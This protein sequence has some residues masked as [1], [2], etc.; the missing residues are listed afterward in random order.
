MRRLALWLLSFAFV[1]TAQAQLAPNAP[2][3]KPYDAYGQAQVDAMHKAIAPYVAQGQATYPAA[4]ARYLAGLPAGETFYVS[5]TLRESPGLEETVFIRVTSI[6]HGVVTG[7]L[8]SP[9]R[10]LHG[11]KL[12]QVQ[13]IP[14]KDVQDWLISRPDGTEEGNV[15]G[16]FLDTYHPP[17]S[18][19]KEKCAVMVSKGDGKTQLVVLPS[20]HV[21]TLSAEGEPFTLPPDAPA[22]SVAVDCGRD[23]IVP[24]PYDYRVVAAD[25]PFIITVADEGRLAALEIKDGRLQFRMMKG[26]VTPSEERQIQEF[27]DR[28][29]P[30]LKR[31]EKP[32]TQATSEAPPRGAG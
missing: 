17:T 2:P 24:L 11:Y 13:S 28:V 3:D 29:Q 23:S 4:K 10:V 18:P 5:T 12:G 31:E 20:L 14:E 8:S 6:E 26:D 16:K 15:V 19:P 1:G 27:I 22:G 9:I 25:Y 30:L 7:A 21:A 32:K